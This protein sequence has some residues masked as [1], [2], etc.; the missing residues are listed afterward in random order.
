MIDVFLVPTLIQLTCFF[1]L[2][3]L[4]VRTWSRYHP[5]LHAAADNLGKSVCRGSTIRHLVA[6]LCD[7]KNPPVTQPDFCMFETDCLIVTVYWKSDDWRFD[8][9]L[10]LSQ[11]WWWAVLLF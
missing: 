8:S 3:T 1:P 2:P 9:K 6:F 7:V 5:P 10:W 4:A 11:M